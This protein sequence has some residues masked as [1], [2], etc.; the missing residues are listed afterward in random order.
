[1]CKHFVL[2]YSFVLITNCYANALG[3]RTCETMGECPPGEICK[4]YD[5]AGRDILALFVT[6]RNN[7]HRPQFCEPGCL[8]TLKPCPIGEQCIPLNS[9]K[10]G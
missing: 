8:P 3:P 10:I 9:G 4:E 7:E 6:F 5:G 1:M 2:L